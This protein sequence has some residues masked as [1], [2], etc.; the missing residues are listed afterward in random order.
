M[1]RVTGLEDCAFMKGIV[2]KPN[3]DVK[4]TVKSSKVF[5][6]PSNSFCS[7][8]AFNIQKPLPG[9]FCLINLRVTVS[10]INDKSD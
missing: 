9:I 1:L 6:S 10:V 2:G 7:K 4:L 8:L 5:D 3:C